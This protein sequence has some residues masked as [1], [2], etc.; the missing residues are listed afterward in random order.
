[1]PG[2]ACSASTSARA[3]HRVADADDLAARRGRA[4]RPPRARRRGSRA[5]RAG[6]PAARPTRR[7]RGSRSPT[8]ADPREGPRQRLP[9]GAVEPGGVAEEHRAPGPAELVH[10]E[11]RAGRRQELAHP[12]QGRFQRRWHTTPAPR[13]SWTGGLAARCGPARPSS[14]RRSALLEQG[15]LRP[16]APR[17]AEAAVVSVRSIFQHFDDL[18]TLHAAVAE[19][20]VERVSL[21][22]VPRSPPTAARRA[23]RP[24]RPPAG[25]AARGG[26]PDPP[27]RRRARPVLVGDHRSARATVRPSCARS[28]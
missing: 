9:H 2:R 14:T 6:G 21:L 7:G 16:T 22:L 24:L 4:R 13:R 25:A 12:P 19:R 1:M 3:A 10:R 15:D 11:R 17:V 8:A 23:P 28:S 20:L 18:E 27:S 26:E 5:S